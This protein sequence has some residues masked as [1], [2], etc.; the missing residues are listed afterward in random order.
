MND[1]LRTAFAN[2][3]QL[4]DQD[5]A[6]MAAAMKRDAST[7]AKRHNRL[8]NAGGSDDRGKARNDAERQRRADLRKLK[9][10]WL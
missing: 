5:L 7:A 3:A 10:A 1:R 2:P 4:T 9:L 8:Q 6:D